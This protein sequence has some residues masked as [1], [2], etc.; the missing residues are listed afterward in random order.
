[1]EEEKVE[2][3]RG[4]IPVI[5]CTEERDNRPLREVGRNILSPCAPLS[6]APHRGACTIHWLFCDV[7]VV[8][9]SF[10]PSA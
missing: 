1:M 7:N 9:R 8:T 5:F 10:S 3:L 6:K 4:T 2:S